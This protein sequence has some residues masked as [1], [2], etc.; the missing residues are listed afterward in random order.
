MSVRVGLSSP[1]TFLACDVWRA[2]A[3]EG[4]TSLV[5]EKGAVAQGEARLRRRAREQGWSQEPGEGGALLAACPACAS[6]RFAALVAGVDSLPPRA[7]P[8]FPAPVAAAVGEPRAG[9]VGPDGVDAGGAGVDV[10]QH[11]GRARPGHVAHH[12]VPLV[13]RLQQRDQ[14]GPAGVVQ[15]HPVDVLRAARRVARGEG[16]EHRPL[17]A[18]GIDD[19]DPLGDEDRRRRRGGGRGGRERRGGRG[20]E[21]RRGD[22]QRG[23]RRGQGGTGGHHGPGR[24]ARLPGGGRRRRDGL[25]R[26]RVRADDG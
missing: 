4:R 16:P 17:L 6:A 9:A 2:S 3:C 22:H 13:G 12:E 1:A 14:L 19:D 21:G 20:G 7:A 5:V 11:R 24:E 25:G 8:P 23:R 15:L 26:G 18:A 10:D